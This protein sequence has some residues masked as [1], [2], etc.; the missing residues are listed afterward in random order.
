MCSK[1]YMPFLTFFDVVLTPFAG[2]CF[3]RGSSSISSCCWS[4]SID[5]LITTHFLS[6]CFL[7]IS[8]GLWLQCLSNEIYLIWDGSCWHVRSMGVAGGDWKLWF[9]LWNGNGFLSR[10]GIKNLL[11]CWKTCSFHFKCSLSISFFLAANK[12]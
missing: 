4:R 3:F 12:W 7:D 2:L 5:G 10:A 8:C 11:G 9:I 6:F 1:P